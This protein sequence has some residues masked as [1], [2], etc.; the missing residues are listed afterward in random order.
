MLHAGVCVPRQYARFAGIAYGHKVNRF[1][2]RLVEQRYAGVSTCR[3]NRAGLYHIRHH[4]LYVAIGQPDSRYRRP[5]SAQLAIERLMLLD[6][7]L[8]NPDVIWLG[9]EA[10]KV[11]FFA[12]MAPSLPCERL[13]HALVGKGT[14]ARVRLF[15]EQ[16][17]IGLSPTGRAF[18]LFSAMPPFED[19]IRVFVQR[20]HDVRA[21]PGWTLRLLVP[22]QP[23]CPSTWF[24]TMARAELTRRFAP[25]TI[26]EL[27]WYCGQ[28]RDTLDARARSR[29]DERF[30]L[31]RKAFTGPECQVLYQ[32]WLI[33]GD[34]V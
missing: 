29:I 10:E 27:K 13:P 15:P 28:C 31:A 6:G 1:F 22:P 3:H 33:D 34:D 12:L 2:D 11:A 32:R 24:E 17:P 14:S 16:L 20:H 5:V 25:M 7:M 30:W 26:E 21:L 23:K 9:D 4:A 8:T 19:R 18:F